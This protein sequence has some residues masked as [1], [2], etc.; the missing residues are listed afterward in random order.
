[1]LS[2]AD[3]GCRRVAGDLRAL[4]LRNATFD[5]VVSGLA[6]VDI[7]ELHVVA[8]EF[9]RVLKPA[10]VVVYSTLHPTGEML[11]WKRTFDTPQGTRT[12][13]AHWH[14]LAEHRAA[15]AAAGLTI[16]RLLEPAIGARSSRAPA[17][18]VA[19]VV[20]ARRSS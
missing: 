20:R 4:P 19:L 2:A 16:E 12:L 15:C 1:M 18:R 3:R 6:L 11:A 7:P 5:L 9:A 10:G 17:S 8:A 14:P 13:P